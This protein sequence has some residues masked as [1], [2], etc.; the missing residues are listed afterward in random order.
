MLPN[1]KWLVAVTLA[2]WG[3]STLTGQLPPRARLLLLLSIAFGL[4]AGW[5]VRVLADEFKV[6]PSRPLAAVVCLLTV[7]GLV[8]VAWTAYRQM[9]AAARAITDA[10]PQQLLALR[11]LES[12][13]NDDPTMQRRFREERARLQP[14]FADYLA[15]RLSRLGRPE[16]PWPIV[17]WIA[18]ILL[19][20]FAAGWMFRRHVQR[21]APGGESAATIP[22]S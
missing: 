4:L 20:G 18:E 16:P 14:I 1:L 7:A 12:S 8:N 11:V 19:G 3:L 2:V 6:S 17:I 10:D 5:G 22:A 15:D 21:Q 13:Q 9:S